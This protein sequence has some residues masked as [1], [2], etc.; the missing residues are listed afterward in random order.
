LGWSA[1]LKLDAYAIDFLLQHLQDNI[2][3]ELKQLNVE[4]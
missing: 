2:E 3:A 1:I 4:E